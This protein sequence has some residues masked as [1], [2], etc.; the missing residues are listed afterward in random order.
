M[1]TTVRVL[2]CTGPTDL[3]RQYHGQSEPQPAYL[4]LDLRDGILRADYDS[5]VGPAAPA[6]VH[7]GFERRW[8]IPLLTLWKQ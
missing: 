8:G 7:H 4:E 1:A 6:A 3:F 5:E 2:D